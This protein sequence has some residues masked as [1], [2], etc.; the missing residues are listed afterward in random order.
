MDLINISNHPELTSITRKATRNYLIIDDRNEFVELCICVKHFK[1]E[2]PSTTIKDIFPKLIVDKTTMVDAN[3]VIV[4]NDSPNAVM[5]EWEFFKILGG[6]NIS[7]DTL[8]SQ[9]IAWADSIG[10]L[11]RY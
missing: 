8:C 6:Q 5:N 7:I 1:D 10:R 2:L 4:D 11:N 9:K 3:G